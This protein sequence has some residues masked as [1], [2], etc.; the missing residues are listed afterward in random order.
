MSDSI[1]PSLWIASIVEVD[2]GSYW[3]SN[4]NEGVY[5]IKNEKIINH[6]DIKE[7]QAIIQDQD[8]NIWISSLNN[9]VYKISPHYNAHTHHDITEFGG[10]AISA[11]NK[12][13]AGVWM[14]NG[15]RVYLYRNQSFLPLDFCNNE[16]KL[17]IVFC[18]D[19]ETLIVGEKSRNHYIITNVKPGRL[20]KQLRYGECH[21]G[22]HGS[23]MKY[24]AVDPGTGELFYFTQSKLFVN[25]K[26]K[27]I[28]IRGKKF[29]IGEPNSI[30]SFLNP[31]RKFG[32]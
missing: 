30:K 5:C 6:L 3:Y 16:S 1:L 14:T 7:P 23:G 17:N 19:D 22:H 26:R 12:S 29:H 9:R 11:L 4:Y 21:K 28:W 13:L 8:G 25:P 20:T 24:P 15:E 2:D 27:K 10:S 32:C 18:L 31:E